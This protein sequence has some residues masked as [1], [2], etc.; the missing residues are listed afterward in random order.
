MSWQTINNYLTSFFRYFGIGS[1]ND[2]SPARLG[3]DQLA[4][5]GP[6]GSSVDPDANGDFVLSSKVDMEGSKEL[7]EFYF[8]NVLSRAEEAQLPK[9]S[10]C[11]GSISNDIHPTAESWIATS[12]YEERK[13][14]FGSDRETNGTTE[15]GFSET[16]T[17]SFPDEED[18]VK[19]SPPLL[20]KDAGDAEDSNG[21]RDPT[22]TAYL[23]RLIQ[24]QRE[25]TAHRP[26]ALTTIREDAS[27][28]SDGAD[29]GGT[30]AL[31]RLRPLAPVAIVKAPQTQSAQLRGRVTFNPPLFSECDF[32]MRILNDKVCLEYV[33]TDSDEIRGYVRVLNTTY[34]KHVTVDYTTN[35]WATIDKIDARW[36]NT[37][38][39]G[40][41][42]RFLFTIPGRRSVGDLKFSVRFNGILDD[43]QGRAYTIH[44]EKYNNL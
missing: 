24:H 17:V 18:S 39:L 43:N 27:T 38:N 6:E 11:A 3:F 20:G 40:K 19:S 44:Y 35:N 14:V 26:G 9:A 33:Q 16:K 25:T 8:N 2:D 29:D 12:A 42:D 28:Q 34:A 15:S 37:M 13:D 23:E 32:E 1:S 5:I 22:S 36:I 31:Y 30:C 41:M 10:L 7:E 4:G 21:Y